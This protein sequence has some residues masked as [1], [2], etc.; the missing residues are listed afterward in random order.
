MLSG[1][2]YTDGARKRFWY[3][4]E[5]ARAGWGFTRFENGRIDVLTCGA[6]PGPAQTS[7]I[8]EL[9]AFLQ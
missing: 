5:A 9:Y 4:P 7:P 6:L 8:S 3:W 1:V 2:V